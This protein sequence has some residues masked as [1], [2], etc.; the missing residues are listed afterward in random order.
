MRVLTQI[1]TEQQDG[2]TVKLVLRRHLLMSDGLISRIKLR[3]RGICLNGQRVKTIA[4]V[5]TGDRLE[6]EIGDIPGGRKTLPNA[7]AP[8][9]VYEDEDLIVLNKPAGLAVHGSGED[10][11]LNVV[12]MLE[13]YLNGDPIH[14]LTRLD[15]GTSGLMAVAKNAYVT[16]RLRHMMHTPDFER[17]YLAWTVGAPSPLCGVITLPIA[18]DADGYKRIISPDGVYAET[19][20]ET[21]EQ[22]NRLA[23][24]RLRLVTGRTHQIRVHMAAIGSPLLGDWMYG[25]D[26]SLIDRPALHSA[27]LRLLHPISN[28]LLNLSAPLPED[29]QSLHNL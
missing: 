18:P 24:V 10:G 9:I 4:L 23:L 29:M 17:K 12:T 26:S 8:N 20:Y 7:P 2:L 1:I 25:T 21:L 3:P 14:L 16:D 22:K 19:H 11:D 5:H 28:K 6:V 15:R 13:T 27:Q